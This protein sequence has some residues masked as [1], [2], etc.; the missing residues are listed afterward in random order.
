M[1]PTNHL[2]HHQILKNTI[3]DTAIEGFGNMTNR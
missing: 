3:S 1:S 2:L